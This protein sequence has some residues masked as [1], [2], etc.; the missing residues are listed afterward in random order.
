MLGRL[1]CCSK[2]VR[3]ADSVF[4]I[5]S[6]QYRVGDSRP[7]EER[8]R[9]RGEAGASV[10]GG[11][12]PNRCIKIGGASQI[13][14]GHNAWRQLHNRKAFYNRPGSSKQ[15]AA[16]KERRVL[17]VIPMRYLSFARGTASAPLQPCRLLALAPSQ[18]K[19][20]Y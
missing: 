4:A 2:T 12:S 15:R 1:I 20:N 11:L 8:E 10:A 14:C 9:E 16:L 7:Q 18:P 19:S 3:R 5:T 13:P 17:T 6:P